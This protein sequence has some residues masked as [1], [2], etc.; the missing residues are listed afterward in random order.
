MQ[1]GSFSFYSVSFRLLF[2]EG[3][4]SIFLS[5]LTQDCNKVA[6]SFKRHLLPRNHIILAIR[7][8]LLNQIYSISIVVSIIH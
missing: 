8:I 1:Q 3:M 6:L 5:S 7:M 4:T 2:E